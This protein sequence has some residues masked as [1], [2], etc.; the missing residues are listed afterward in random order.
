MNRST[1]AELGQK[2]K[3][4]A[5]DTG[6][7]EL[8]MAMQGFSDVHVGWRL[9]RLALEAMNDEAFDGAGLEA[10]RQGSRWRLSPGP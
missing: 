8:V 3:A 1:A 10:E 7:T 2:L 5:V 6:D 9:R 4:W